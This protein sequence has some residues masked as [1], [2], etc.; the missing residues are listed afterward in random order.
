[1]RSLPDRYV[2]AVTTT[3]GDLGGG[4]D[5]TAAHTTRLTPFHEGDGGWP[6]WHRRAGTSALSLL[7]ALVPGLVHDMEGIAVQA[8]GEP[9]KS[10]A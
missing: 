3:R 1:M 4:K 6:V 8:S 10:M 2:V 5:D 9:F 7:G